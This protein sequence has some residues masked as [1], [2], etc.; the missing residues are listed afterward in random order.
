MKKQGFGKFPFPRIL[1]L[2][3]FLF[4]SKDMLFMKKFFFK[5]RLILGV[6]RQ[7]SKSSASQKKNWGQV[8]SF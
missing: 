5:I 7:F 2:I 3:F 1:L 8:V 4:F 6:L